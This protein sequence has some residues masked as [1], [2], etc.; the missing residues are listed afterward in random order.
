MRHVTYFILWIDVSSSVEK[1]SRDINM[2][3]TSCMMQG[4]PTIL[5]SCRMRHQIKNIGSW[6]RWRNLVSSHLIR[7]NKKKYNLCNYTGLWLIQ[8]TFISMLAMTLTW[9]LYNNSDLQ[10]HNDA[11]NDTSNHHDLSRHITYFISCIDVNSCVKKQFHDFGM[12]AK[13]G[14]M[15]G[16]P[17]ILISYQIHYQ[18]INI[19]CWV[20]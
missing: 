7:P 6:V 11:V 8:V 1:Q 14:K 20:R 18:I 2:T 19:V 13:S 15:K 12:P 9:R 17:A 3:S 16:C 5:I 10:C 4:C